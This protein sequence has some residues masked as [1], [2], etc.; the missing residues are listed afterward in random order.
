[1]RIRQLK[2]T[3]IIVKAKAP[4]IEWANSLD[5][6]GVKL[7]EDLEPEHTVYLI[8]DMTGYQGDVEASVRMWRML[9]PLPA[10]G[11]RPAAPGPPWGCPDQDGSPSSG[12]S[13]Q[14]QCLV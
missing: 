13:S 10:I 9:Y 6:D 2:R 1:M 5:D 8:E 7:G 11:I 14:V 3:A 4:Y 12:C